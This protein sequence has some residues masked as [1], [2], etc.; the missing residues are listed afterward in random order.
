M[1]YLREIIRDRFDVQAGNVFSR[2]AAVT[3][4]N[5]DKATAPPGGSATQ[6]RKEAPQS[7]RV[8]PV[9][10]LEILDETVTSLSEN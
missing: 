3:V 10:L 9:E 5:D 7:S 4:T 6:K 1:S 8:S 2:Q